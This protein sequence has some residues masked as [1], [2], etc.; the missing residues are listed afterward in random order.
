M[1]E[2]KAQAETEVL[3]AHE[4]KVRA[5]KEKYKALS[6]KTKLIKELKC[7]LFFIT[8]LILLRETCLTR[9]PFSSIVVRTNAQAWFRDFK[10]WLQ[11]NQDKMKTIINGIKPMLDFINPELSE[12]DRP[13]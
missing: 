5:E 4:A 7:M 13:P 2:A 10:L 8:M 3:L 12:P 1:R 11:A 9:L 6:T